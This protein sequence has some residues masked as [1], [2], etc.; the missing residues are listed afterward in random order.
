LSDTP[1]DVPGDRF[2]IEAILRE[3]YGVGQRDSGMQVHGP[4]HSM[5]FSQLYRAEGVMLPAPLAVKACI[6]PVTRRPDP[7]AARR[8]FAALTHAAAAFD[9]DPIL[10]VP[11]PRFLDA[12][13]GL[14]GIDWVS[15]RSVTHHLRR[16]AR[17]SA[18]TSLAARAGQWL[19]RLHAARPLA[20]GA[21][22]AHAKL[23]FLRAE[24]AAL[25]R[26]EPRFALGVDTLGASVEVVAATPVPR[27]W[28]HGDFKA[29]NLLWTGTAMYGI[30]MTLDGETTVLADLSSFLS[31][32]SL[33]L[34]AHPRLAPPGR[35]GEWRTALSTSYFGGQPVPDGPLA[36]LELYSIL[37][38]WL[39]SDTGRR[40]WRAA[41][42]RTAFRASAR[43]LARQLAAKYG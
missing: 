39:A 27:S 29:D 2:A 18:H 30:D 31:H 22:D 40:G 34:R 13:R 5:R 42:L 11:T 25:V 38:V 28:A 3:R 33:D 32:L 7:D 35:Y 4:L 6:H 24:G 10:R 12:D 8:Q 23:A 9:D 43:A 15:G 16:P 1:T 26:G 14:L 20:P 19:A 36:W 17:T 21:V 37:R 41:I